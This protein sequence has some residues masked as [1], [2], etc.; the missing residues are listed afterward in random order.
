MLPLACQ[1]WSSL[2]GVASAEA[3]GSPCTGSMKMVPQTLSLFTFAWVASGLCRQGTRVTVCG[4]PCLLWLESAGS[5]ISFSPPNPSPHVSDQV[6]GAGGDERGL[7]VASG[8]FRAAG[9]WPR[10][11][12]VDVHLGCGSDSSFGFLTHLGFCLKPS[13]PFSGRGPFCFTSG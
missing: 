2:S 10:T 4:G 1:F 11:L 7:G 6:V 9:T 13:A 5:Q 12:W 8:L 3:C